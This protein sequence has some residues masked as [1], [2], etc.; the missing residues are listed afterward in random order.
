MEG[1]SLDGHILIPEPMLLSAPIILPSLQCDRPL[2]HLTGLCWLCCC[3]TPFTCCLSLDSKGGGTCHHRSQ[4]KRCSLSHQ[5]RCWAC[6]S[7]QGLL[8]DSVF[9]GNVSLLVRIKVMLGQD[10][11]L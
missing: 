3:V 1:Q 10:P 2:I 8:Y 4:S 5:V 7:S 6:G 9:T 11:P